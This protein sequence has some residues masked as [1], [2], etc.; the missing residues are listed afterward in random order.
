[1]L[2]NQGLRRGTRCEHAGYLALEPDHMLK[3][4]EQWP[5]G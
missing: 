1:M 2:G 5:Q 4:P 3:I